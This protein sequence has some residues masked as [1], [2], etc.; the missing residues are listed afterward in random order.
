MILGSTQIKHSGETLVNAKIVVATQKAIGL[1]L[2]KPDFRNT[3]R[4]ELRH[5]LGLGHANDNGEGA[6]DLMHPNYDFITVG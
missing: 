3:L 6:K 4:H 5:A 1:P 2:E